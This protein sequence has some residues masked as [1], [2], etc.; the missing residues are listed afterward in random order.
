[1]DELSFNEGLAVEVWDKTHRHV[2]E[3]WL[4]EVERLF[5]LCMFNC[6]IKIFQ[7]TE[8]I[9]ISANLAIPAGIAYRELECIRHRPDSG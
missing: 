1:M 5:P 8:E 9:R 7:C 2:D 6:F 4:G 3:Q